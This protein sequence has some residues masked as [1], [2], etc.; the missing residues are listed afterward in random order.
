MPTSTTSH[1]SRGDL[2]LAPAV[3]VGVTLGPVLVGADA[4]LVYMPTAG[5]PDSSSAAFASLSL[6][7]QLGLRL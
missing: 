5:A 2:Y 1:A 3:L 6:G 4:T 7:G